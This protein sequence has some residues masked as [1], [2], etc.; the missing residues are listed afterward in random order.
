MADQPTPK[1][2]I[3]DY[4]LLGDCQTAALVGLDGSVDW[5]CWPRFDS[6][7]C[8]A[9]MLG[10]GDHGRFKIVPTGEIRRTSRRYRGDSLILETTFETDEGRVTVVDFM[11][12]RGE[13][14]DLIRIVTGVEGKVALRM[15]LTLRFG[16][17]K[18]VPWVTRLDDGTLRAIAGPDMVILRTPAET[19]GE[20]MST[21]A[22]ITVSAGETIPFVLTYGLSHRPIPAVVDAD[23]ALADTEVFWTEWSGKYQP[24]SMDGRSPLPSHWRTATMRSLITL[25]ALTYAPTGGIVAAPTTSLPEWIGGE[26]N[27]DYR[28]CWLRDSAVTLFAFMN[29]GYFDEA[30]AWRDWL[31]R[32]MAGSADQLQIMYGL[33]G[34]RRLDEWIADW[35]PGFAGSAPVR[36]GNGA[37]GQL[38]LDVYGEVMSLL[39]QARQGGLPEDD[40]AWNLQRSML[41]HLATIWRDPDEGIWEVRGPRRHFTFSKMMCWVAFD[42]CIRTAEEFDVGACPID[43]W[44]AIRDEIHRDVCAKGFDS[45]LGA[46][47]QYYGSKGLDAS[48]LLLPTLGFL[49]A[50]DPRVR[51]TVEAIEHGLVEGGFVMRYR[52]EAAVDGLPPGE[53]A[54]LACSFWLA[55]ALAEIGRIADGKALFE[56]LLAL[57]NDVGLLAEEYDAGSERQLG[58]FPQA[59]SHL[60]LVSASHRLMM[61]QEASKPADVPVELGIAAG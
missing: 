11:P 5:L 43:K 32:A 31:I 60:A 41:E 14:S 24:E 12:P 26:R 37:S 51:G 61:A 35:L 18:I 13:A 29:G 10:T 2:R 56:R 25:K 53:G 4:A 1:C 40:Q 59:F 17:G 20:G 21:V 19:R 42:R 58:N 8:F 34:E 54:F 48:L 23:A 22:D 50:D 38:Q 57:V 44:R 47:T 39:H 16:Y 36:I 30:Q 15:E 6:G 28:Y 49:P 45:E 3:E 52:T 7:A 46:F 33:A 27:W 9:A 55:S